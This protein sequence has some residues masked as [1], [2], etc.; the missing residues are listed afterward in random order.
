MKHFTLKSLF[1]LFI[2]FITATTFAQTELKGKVADFLTFQ[3]IESAS[4][5]IENTT[6][7]SITNADGNFV[8]K[9][10]QQ[11]LQDTLVISSIGY[12]SFRVVI[13]EFENGSDIFL[14]EDVASLDEVV[15]VADPRPTTGNGIVERAIEKLPKNLPEQAYLQKG[16]LRHK[17][18]NKK[19]Y[20]WLIE[21][22]I[23]LYD[24]SYAA[25]AK[26]NLKIN[27]DE[28]RKSYDLRDVDSLFTYSAYLKSMNSKAS[29]LN[30]NSIK[31]SS[32]IEAIKWNDS[33]VN[34]LENLFKGKLNLVRNSNV[35]G[36]LLGKNMLEKHQFELDTILVDNGRKIYKIKIEKG[37]DF[38]GLNTPNI[39]N[40]GFEP[41]G[42]IYIYYDNYAIKKVE[43]ELVAASDVQKKRSKSLFDTQTI[44]KLVMTYKD[45]DGKMYPNYI[46]YETPKLVNTGDRSSDRIKTEAEPGF[47]KDEQY[48]YTIQEILFSDIIQD[49][50]LVKQ[51]LR[52]N[53]WSADIFSSKPYNESFWKSYNVLLESKEEEKLIQDLSKR[54]SLYKE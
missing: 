32:L 37:T 33:R 16:F 36:A 53:D 31:T 44:H 35:T 20:K 12:K 2:F 23:T 30:R 46:Y 10:P 41:K 14:E 3:P 48:Y 9:V 13:S 42:W 11:H 45:Y 21:S 18:R 1:T 19:E 39:Y 24:S 7:G 34:G 52:Q 51:E 6:I 27:V 50:E 8:L 38:V 4:V 17:E 26:D 22:A 40:E 47:D 5:Y 54:A 25:G 43:Y 28:T 49:P 15:I 29:N